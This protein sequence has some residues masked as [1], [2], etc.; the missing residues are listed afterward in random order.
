MEIVALI[1]YFAKFALCTF[2][3]ANMGNGPIFGNVT[4]RYYQV[5]IDLSNALFNNTTS[6]LCSRITVVKH[7]HK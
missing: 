2:D 1:P 3:I 7:S 6:T 4:R 5:I